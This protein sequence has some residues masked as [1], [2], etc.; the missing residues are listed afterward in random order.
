MTGSASRTWFVPATPDSLLGIQTAVI[1]HLTA[2]RGEPSSEQLDRLA[3]VV[4]TL[5]KHGI[6]HGGSVQVETT[7]TVEANVFTVAIVDRSAG[8]LHTGFAPVLG[9]DALAW[10]VAPRL[11][12]DGRV[13]WARFDLDHD[14]GGRTTVLRMARSPGGRALRRAL[15]APVARSARRW[16]RS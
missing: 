7:V 5:V 14:R 4:R 6:H 12:G 10:G 13:L 2:A 16:L 1:S 3:T 15:P 9:A 8:P 11:H